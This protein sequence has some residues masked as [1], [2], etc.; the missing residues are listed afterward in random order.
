[1]E[2]GEQ[3]R[4]VDS[5]ILGV[6]EEDFLVPVDLLVS[7]EPHVPEEELVDLEGLEVGPRREDRVETLGKPLA[8]GD[9]LADVRVLVLDQQVLDLLKPV[10]DVRPLFVFLEGVEQ[11]VQLLVELFVWREK[12]RGLWGEKGK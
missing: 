2:K 8:E 5:Q 7:V 10:P 3:P 11:G 12:R 6:R 9:F 4:T 1:M